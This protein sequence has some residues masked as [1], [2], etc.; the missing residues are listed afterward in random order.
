M[1]DLS[2]TAV[3]DAAINGD[4]K[5]ADL[6]AIVVD[7]SGGDLA[8]DTAA[9]DALT[10]LEEG[11]IIEFT[12]GTG[13]GYLTHTCPLSGYAYAKHFSRP[14]EGFQIQKTALGYEVRK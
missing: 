6:L 9:L 4:L 10:D 1:I 11:D 7:T 14:G 2:D 13:G 5:E 8:V 3:N 12:V